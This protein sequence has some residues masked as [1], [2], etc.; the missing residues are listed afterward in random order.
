VVREGGANETEAR[1]APG[2]PDEQASHQ[3]QS[4]SE[5]L[6]STEQHLRLLDGRALSTE[7]QAMVEQVRQFSAQAATA[8]AAGDLVR[9]R[10]LA[11]KAHL[12][13]DDL[14]RR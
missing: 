2:M 13:S 6:S 14:V 8:L 10:N 5:L 9:A 7:K 12:L 1:L 4:T 3:R 11:L